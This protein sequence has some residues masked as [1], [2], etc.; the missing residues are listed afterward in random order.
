MKFNNGM[1]VND[2]DAL[3]CPNC[4]CDYVHHGRVEIFH[5]R[6]DAETGCHVTLDNKGVVIVDES[7]IDNP[8]PRRHGVKIFFWCEGCD[9]TSLLTIIQHKGCTYFDFRGV[10]KELV[11][12][13]ESL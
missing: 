12:T 2:E 7:Q 3:C 6:E 4:G 8:S 11:A 1:I 5:R 9:R 13:D 10:A